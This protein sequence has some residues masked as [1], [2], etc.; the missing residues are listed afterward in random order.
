MEQDSK[1][2]EQQ[3]SRIDFKIS[4]NA[5]PFSVNTLTEA[6][7]FTLCIQGTS[8]GVGKIDSFLA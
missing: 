8:R 1:W 3:N 6:G 4:G 2:N 7:Q 5:I